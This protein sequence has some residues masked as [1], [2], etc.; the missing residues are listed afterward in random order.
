MKLGLISLSGEQLWP[1]LH[2]IA[3]WHN[4]ITHLFLLHTEDQRR[5]KKPAETIQK[6]V[7]KWKP[8]VCVGLSEGQSLPFS[9]SFIDVFNLIAIWI[10]NNPEIDE[11]IINATSGTKIML[12]SAL[13]FLGISKVRIIYR[14]L[15]TNSWFEIQPQNPHSENL[16]PPK[17]ILIPNNITDIFPV[18]DLVEAIWSDAGVFHVKF[19]ELPPSFNLIEVTKASASFVN[20]WNFKEGFKKTFTPFKESEGQVFEKYMIGI[21]REMGVTNLAISA[22]RNMEATTTQEADIILNHQGNITILDLKLR[23][24]DEPDLDNKM[25]NQIRDADRIRTELG[26]LGAKSILL[27]PNQRLSKINR[28]LAES[29]RIEYL[30]LDDTHHLIP[31]LANKILGTMNKNL[32]EVQEIISQKNHADPLTSTFPHS[33]LS[34]QNYDS[35][36]KATHVL[37][38]DSMLKKLQNDLGSNWCFFRFDQSIGI[39][40]ELPS[41]WTNTRQSFQQL[42]NQLLCFFEAKTQHL[43]IQ[44]QVEL[45]KNKRA[46]VFFHPLDYKVLPIEPFIKLFRDSIG[47]SFILN[48]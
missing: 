4:D 34:L 25:F 48:D 12:L 23:G 35:D 44:V 42:H 37:H 40:F 28:E 27:R 9:G 6:F 19:G 38:F 47:G 33:P 7:K 46:R 39:D 21:L 1:T 2:C 13:Q 29:Y 31:K 32:E 18:K 24:K 22:K 43:E 16:I 41:N 17:D 36:T 30:D 26:G 45:G 14:E 11:W 3:N 8:H 20:G 10:K 5:S 15:S